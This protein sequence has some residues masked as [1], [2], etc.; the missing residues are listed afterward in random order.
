M[1]NQKHGDIPIAPSLRQERTPLC[2]PGTF[3]ACL[4]L[5]QPG[6]IQAGSGRTRSRITFLD[7]TTADQCWEAGPE[8]AGAPWHVGVEGAHPAHGKPSDVLLGDRRDFPSGVCV[9]LSAS[10]SWHEHGCGG[11]SSVLA[12]STTGSLVSISIPPLNLW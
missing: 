1:L 8:S 5:D 9:T 12:C 11:R 7:G 2:I 4:G 10:S 6:R 3:S